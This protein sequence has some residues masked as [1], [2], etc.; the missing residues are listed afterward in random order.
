MP[1]SDNAVSWVVYATDPLGKTPGLKVVCEQADW[2][3]LEL[4]QPGRYALVKSGIANEAEAERLARGTSG[5]ART[6]LP[7]RP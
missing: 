7:R 3:R 2:D 1:R 4:A 5:D 6:R